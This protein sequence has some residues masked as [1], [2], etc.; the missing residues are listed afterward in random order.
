M[1]QR[2]INAVVRSVKFSSN[3]M[4]LMQDISTGSSLRFFVNIAR[5]I[6]G[7]RA[8]SKRK[9]GDYPISF[10]FILYL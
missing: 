1:V 4:V 5:V 8:K 2:F 10:M 7:K 9:F 6:L 3:N